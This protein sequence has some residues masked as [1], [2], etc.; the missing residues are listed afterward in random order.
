LIL[1]R[2]GFFDSLQA[3]LNVCDSPKNGQKV[4]LALW[5]ADNSP[6]YH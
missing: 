2:S 5:R 4:V 1:S 3:Q 6:N